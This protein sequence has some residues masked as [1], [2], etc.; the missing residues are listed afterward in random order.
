MSAPREPGSAQPSRRNQLLALG[1]VLLVAVVG[2]AIASGRLASGS[3]PTTSPPASAQASAQASLP[4]VPPPWSSSAA[5]VPYDAVFTGDA[6]GATDV[7]AALKAFLESHDGQRVALAVEGEYSVTQLSFTANNLT[8]DF[9]GSRSR[10]RKRGPRDLQDDVELP[11]SSTMPASREPA[12]SGQAALRTPINGN[13]ASRSTVAP[14]SPSTIR[15]PATPAAT[16]STSAR[17]TARRSR[18]RVS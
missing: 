7:T 18:Q 11:S 8:V 2:I 12:M 13:T 10:A 1:A 3:T 4:S 5:V 14:I 9:R 15:R 17:T 6:T 16:G